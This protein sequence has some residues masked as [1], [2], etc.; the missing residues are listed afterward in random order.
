MKFLFTILPIL[1]SF[2]FSQVSESKGYLP[3]DWSGQNGIYHRYGFLGW[4]EDAY[5]N[6]LTFDGTFSNW[7]PRYEF[8]FGNNSE[9]SEK[10]SGIESSIWYRK[11][12]YYLDEFAFDVNFH[13]IGGKNYSLQALK[14]N[15][16][17]QYG[18]TGPVENYGGT[19]QQNYK[20]HIKLPQ[21][22]GA[23]WNIG[24]AYYKTTDAIPTLSLLVWEKGFA[25]QDRIIANGVSYQKE[26]ESLQIFQNL[27]AFSQRL[28]LKS[29]GDNSGW[30][31][32]LLSYW[33]QSGFEYHL[34]ERKSLLGNAII[35]Y[36]ALSSNSFGSSD[37]IEGV[38]SFGMKQSSDNLGCQISSGIGFIQ[39]NE[40]G[41]IYHVSGDWVTPWFTFF[42]DIDHTL[43]ATPL[44]MTNLKMGGFTPDESAISEKQTVAKLGIHKQSNRSMLKAEIFYSRVAPHYFYSE[45]SDSNIVLTKKSS[46]AIQGITLH[47]KLNYFRNWWLTTDGISIINNKEGWGSG[48]QHQGT[49]SLTF[50]EYLFQHH[51]DAR[52]RIWSNFWIG[53]NSYIWDPV[54]YAGYNSYRDIDLQNAAG[55]LNAEFKGVISNFEISYTMINILYAFRS[56]LESTFED[57]Q[58]TLSTT[59]LLPSPGRLFYITI[60]WNF[61]D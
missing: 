28:K 3:F 1:I 15:F 7:I 50:Q 36:S 51:L 60:Q 6:P 46:D 52:I 12:D 59:P 26:G 31:V 44:Q 49:V 27:S 16:E 57:E 9:R 61:L 18:L 14:R 17:D 35:K 37:G 38:I 22:D 33:S 13:N 21:K 8:P 40:V 32:D 24:S 34:D 55:V 58:L 25:R 5:D 47:G 53:R 10:E 30:S 48:V 43:S 29:Y 45:L 56:L 54:V 11:G 20:I 39:P 23:E 42:F 4:W 19:V 41:F 2:T